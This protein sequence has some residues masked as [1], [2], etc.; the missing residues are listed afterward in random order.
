MEGI[1]LPNKD[2]QEWFLMEFNYALWYFWTEYGLDVEKFKQ[3]IL[4][5][6][7]ADED[8]LPA[9]VNK[10]GYRAARCV[11]RLEEYLLTQV[12]I[13]QSGRLN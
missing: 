10:Y 4:R 6:D 1:P 13:Y 3:M 12:M 8:L 2:M 5:E 7:V 11:R 9:I